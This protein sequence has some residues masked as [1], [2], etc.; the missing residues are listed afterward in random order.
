MVEL[1]S[2][3]YSL[4]LLGSFILGDAECNSVLKLALIKDFLL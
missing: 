1:H 2:R 4:L 3:Y